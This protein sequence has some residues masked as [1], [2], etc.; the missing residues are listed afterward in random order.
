MFNHVSTR[1]Y[2]LANRHGLFA[3]VR[4]CKT[5]L[6][7]TAKF[8][9]V[10]ISLSNLV[11][12]SSPDNMLYH[13]WTW[14]LIYHDGFMLSHQAWMLFVRPHCSCL[15]RVLVFLVNNTRV[16]STLSLE[17]TPRKFAWVANFSKNGA[18]TEGSSQRICLI[19]FIIYNEL[20]SKILREYH[21]DIHL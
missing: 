9:V 10:V 17:M 15:S 3:Y 21:L 13:A 2:S 7:T 4:T 11:I 20:L 19:T 14:L 1:C 6:D 18:I 16:F 5:R 8:M 12:L